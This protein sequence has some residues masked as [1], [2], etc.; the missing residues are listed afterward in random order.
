MI[1]VIYIYSSHDFNKIMLNK[2]IVFSRSLLKKMGLSSRVYKNFCVC[3]S[4]CLKV[5]KKKCLCKYLLINNE[6]FTIVIFLF[7]FMFN[8]DLLV[9][10]DLYDLMMIFKI[11]TSC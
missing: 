5:N 10:F 11:K 3:Y 6:F 4:C 2:Y 1:I 9:C 7:V 8:Y